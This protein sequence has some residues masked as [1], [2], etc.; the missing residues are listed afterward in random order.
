VRI[1]VFGDV[2]GNSI[3]LDAVLTAIAGQGPVDGYIVLGDLANAGPDPVGVLDRLRALPNA[4]FVRGNGD[5]YTVTGEIPTWF[6][7]ERSEAEIAAM[8]L[9]ITESVAWARGAI[10]AADQY[11]WLAAL[12]F[13]LRV[14][15]P[16]GTR[17]L[18]VHATHRRDDEYILSPNRTDDELRA[19]LADADADLI[20]AGHTHRPLDRTLGD[21]LRI[22]N[23]GC[24]S[25]PLPY[26]DD[27]R[28]GWALLDARTDRHVVTSHLI[29]YDHEAV[30]AQA[31]RVHFPA[32]DFI[33]R[34]QRV[35]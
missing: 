11:D 35:R 34:T 12:P 31:R 8:R 19:I 13:D 26:L 30:A 22:V 24:V 5:R 7:Q 3:A 18:A 4:R 29:D 9:G 28:A 14:A 32:A 23:P 25:N 21:R 2:H 33:A 27:I 6:E 10:T 16:D 17:L 15:L 20:L 1:A